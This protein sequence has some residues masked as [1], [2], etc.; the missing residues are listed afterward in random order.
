MGLSGT[1]SSVQQTLLTMLD[2]LALPTE[3]SVI[4]S[5]APRKITISKGHFFHK[6]E[7]NEIIQ[8]T[9]AGHADVLSE[10]PLFED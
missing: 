7:V 4:M 9:F 3:S 6:V 1:E 5:G 8:L 2:W 10:D